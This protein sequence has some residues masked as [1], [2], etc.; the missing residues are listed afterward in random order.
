MNPC[1]GCQ[2]TIASPKVYCDMC[3]SKGWGFIDGRPASPKEIKQVLFDEY[4]MGTRF[5]ESRVNR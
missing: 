4:L 2:K 1:A 3:W 5:S